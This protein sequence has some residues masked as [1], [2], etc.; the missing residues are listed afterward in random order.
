MQHMQ[1]VMKQTIQQERSNLVI[2][3]GEPVV[4]ELV[5][6]TIYKA[7]PVNRHWIPSLFVLVTKN[8]VA[9]RRES[10]EE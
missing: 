3:R 8:N 2:K 1:G 6:G 9:L 5:K 10:G 7:R 4:L